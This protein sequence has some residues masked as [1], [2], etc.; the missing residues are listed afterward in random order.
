VI[1]RMVRRCA[2]CFLCLAAFQSTA[3]AGVESLRI[4]E[5]LARNDSFLFPAPPAQQPGDP[6]FTTPD[7]VEIYNLSDKFVSLAGLYLT[8]SRPD[9]AASG[10]WWRFPPGSW[11]QPHGRL[12]VLLGGR[13]VEGQ[14]R[15]PFG[16]DRDGE[17]IALVGEDRRTVI[18]EVVFPCQLPDVSYARIPDGTGD[19]AFTSTPTFCWPREG[20]FCTCAGIDEDGDG[21]PDR[22]WC[23]AGESGF[24][25]NQLDDR[26]PPDLDIVDYSPIMPRAEEPVTVTVS[27]SC[28]DTEVDSVR[29]EYRVNGGEESFW[30]DLENQGRPQVEDPEDEPPAYTLWKGEIPGQPADTVV[31]FRVHAAR[32]EAVDVEPDRKW[33][34]YTAGRRSVPPLRINEIQP[35]NLTTAQDG[36]GDFDDWVEV[37]NYGGEELALDDFFL[38][39]NRRRPQKWRFPAGLVLPP[40]GRI[41]VWCDGEEQ[42]SVP[43]EPHANFRLNA[44][45]DD[46]ALADEGGIFQRV[47]WRGELTDLSLGFTEPEGREARFWQPTPGAPNPA[48]VPPAIRDVSPEGPTPEF[49]VPAFVAGEGLD[50]VEA[51][52]F[53]T[54]RGRSPDDST[55]AEDYEPILITNKAS[56]GLRIQSLPQ[57]DPVAR[58]LLLLAAGPFA[59]S[60]P[61]PCNEPFVRG[62]VNGDGKLNIGDVL[63]VLGYLFGG[64]IGPECRDRMDANDDGTVNLADGVYLL[65]YLFGGAP[66]P[67][68]PF[69]EP[70][71]DPTRDVLACPAQ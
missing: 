1:E 48:G 27:V 20:D 23:P 42:E 22:S 69:G 28:H 57:C 41:V 46:V 32:G 33:I 66:E 26:Y 38:T 56:D 71:V 7:L 54:V 68:Q 3:G 25:T 51:G 70:G 24:S 12:T 31:A 14:L 6:L 47:Q 64:G 55:P 53:V 21:N 2:L 29:L 13:A 50:Q 40:G 60:F 37:F 63:A 65:G 34:V 58:H 62:E 17:R 19:F 44:D 36:A 52:F 59:L 45:G 5:I 67:P 30:V 49:E 10:N 35:S 39:D 43:G 18:D 11:I 9:D 16:L 61:L 8:D 4:N 15:A